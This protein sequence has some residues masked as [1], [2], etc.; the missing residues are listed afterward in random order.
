MEKKRKIEE[1]DWHFSNVLK[2]T[3]KENQ[4]SYSNHMRMSIAKFE[5][6]L[7][8]VGLKTQ[9]KTVLQNIITCMKMQLIL[10]Y[11]AS[12]DSITSL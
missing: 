10:L 4:V 5:E 12:G 2:K 6:L 11:L 7:Q 3:G 8:M 9:C 1:C